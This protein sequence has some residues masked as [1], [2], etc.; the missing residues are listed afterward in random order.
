VRSARLLATLDVDRTELVDG[1]V[2]VTDGFVSAV[3]TGVPPTARETIDASGCLVTPGLVNVHHH[4]Y[5]NLTRAY[6]PMTNS[7]LFGWLRTLYPLWRALNEESAHVSAWVGLAELALAGCTTSSDHLYLHPRGAGDLLSAEIA[8]ARDL[9]VRFH[10]TYGSMSLSEKD[11]GLPPDDVVQDHDEILSNSERMVALHHDRKRG[12]MVRIALAPCSPF[13]VTKQLMSESATLAERLDV[14]L[15]THF[16]ENDEDDAYSLA[17]FGCRPTEYLEEVGWVNDR[18]WLAHCVKPND[19]EIRRLGA[20]GVGVAHCPS[21]NLILSSGIAP[22]VK[23]RA[24]GVHVGLGVDGS[25]SADAASLWLESRQA[26]LLAK[27][28]SGASVGTARMALEMATRGGAGCLGRVG[29]IGELS[30]GSVGD[31]AVW[32]LDGPQFAG[33]VDDP[34]EGWLRCGPSSARH[35]IVHGRTVVRD[36]RLVSPRL[37]EMLTDHAR[38]ARRMQH[39]TS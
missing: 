16:A 15:H 11:G 25:S 19:D 9:G 18:A 26:M 2:A 33:V 6:G 28:N 4:L 1:W 23:L 31:I 32:S 8:A 30:V 37:G 7:A 17:T 34:I 14:R 13:S 12:A 24:A 38:L 3:G 35:T 21:S 29:E 36:H 22:T 27:L 39:A 10:P 5:Q 20:A